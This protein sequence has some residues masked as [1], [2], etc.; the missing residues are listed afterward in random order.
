MLWKLGDTMYYKKGVTDPDYCVF[1]FTSIT[2]R[3]YSHFKSV[4]I[5]L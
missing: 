3:Y 2:A 5:E 1:K 4:E